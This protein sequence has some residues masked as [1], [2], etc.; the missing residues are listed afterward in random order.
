MRITRAVHL[1][2]A[3]EKLDRGPGFRPGSPAVARFD[4]GDVPIRER[5]VATERVIDLHP[6]EDQPD[7][8]VG[9]AHQASHRQAVPT[10]VGVDR[11]GFLPVPADIVGAGEHDNTIVPAHRPGA[12]PE[13]QQEPTVL[14][15]HHAGSG[16]V[17]HS[18]GTEE[19]PRREHLDRAMREDPRGGLA[20]RLPLPVPP[21]VAWTSSMG[22]SWR[23]VPLHLQTREPANLHIRRQPWRY[24]S[25]ARRSVSPT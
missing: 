12:E 10:G 6:T 18:R 21:L 4:L 25:S 7:P 24:G 15:A 5:F 1:S 3:G 19:Y 9:E 17:P 2:P 14:E 8:V 23:R 22:G 20:H 11:E 13:C 16:A